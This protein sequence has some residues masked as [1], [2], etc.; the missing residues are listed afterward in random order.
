MPKSATPPQRTESPIAASRIFDP[1]SPRLYSIDQGRPFLADLAG[2]LIDALGQEAPRAEIFLPT[3]RA[4]RAAGDAFMAAYAARGANAAL[5]PRFRAIGDIDDIDL[6]SLSGDAAAEVEFDPAISAVERVI[7]LARFVAAA[8]RR[9]SGQE[10]WPAAIAAA[11]ELGKLLDTFYT[12]EVDPAALDALDIADAAGHWSNA[13][14]FLKIIT[15]RWPLYLQSISRIDPARRR[16]L[17][18]AATA[19]RIERSAPDHPIIIAGTTAS[20]PAVARLVSAIASAPRGLAVLPGLDR[21]ID[22]RAWD[23]IGGEDAHPQAGLHALLARLGVDRSAVKTWPGSN[24]ADS[25]LQ[26]LALALRPAEATDDWLSL[27]AAMT[28]ADAGLAKASEGLSLIEAD[29][30]EA[31]ATAIAALFR[32]TLE[33]P[34]KSAALVTPDR[35]LARRV[36]LKMRRWNVAV[37]DSAGVPFANTSCGIFLRLVALYLENPDDSVGILALLRHPRFNVG[38]DDRRAGAAIDRLDRGLRGAGLPGPLDRLR[39]TLKAD[40]ADD[41]PIRIIDQLTEQVALFRAGADSASFEE[42]FDLHLAAAEA[43]GGGAALWAD[44]DGEAGA[45]ITAEL[46]A[47]ARL[48]ET[49]QGALYADIFNALIAD[50]AVRRSDASHPRLS[51]LGPLEARLQQADLVILGGLNEGVWPQDPPT[52]PFLSRRMRADLGL[53]SPERRTGLSA[54]DFAGLAAQGEVV[55]TRARRAG[56]KPANPSRW[57]IRLKNILTGA[58]AL[59]KVDRSAEWKRIIERLEAPRRVEAA[60]R[61]RPH[62]GPG[63][64]PSRASVTRISSWLRDPYGAYAMYLL[65]LRKIEDPGAP[66]S[67]R[68]MGKL[69]HRAF[70]IAAKD[71]EPPNVERLNEIYAA[72]A[73]QFGLDDADRRFWSVA[74]LKSFVWFAAFDAH[75]RAVGVAAGLEAD[76]EWT[77]PGIDPPFTV[78]AR[79]DRIDVTHDGAAEI[80]DYKLGA[81]PSEKQIRDFSPQ[82]PLIG[83][84][85]EAGG[86]AD[87]GA[88]DVRSYAYLRVANRKDAGA[89]NSFEKSG[90]DATLSIRE[91]TQGL[92]QW[93]RHYDDPA[94]VYLPQPRPE[95]TNDYGD[96]DQ[97]SRRKEWGADEDGD[98]DA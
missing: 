59:A 29:N 7:M 26:L 60:P 14:D 9:F 84:I 36:A 15:Q 94:S 70:E 23:A 30:E 19:E 75:R 12:E 18:I 49:T 76:G 67:Q 46:R 48:I 38:G 39:A 82:L 69:L 34:G 21:T 40:G 3:R 4:V 79:A 64:R 87:I 37:D 88:R 41:E 32:L 89:E 57:I 11:R 17:M 85:I 92:T 80:F 5:L 6:L 27:V 56:G 63:R 77:L 1:Q 53:P 16:A 65:E 58:D 96:Y 68:E 93:V 97:L 28:A 47:S 45:E 71:A 83:A 24:E 52:D 10:N 51:I 81:T 91:A 13:L 25:R 90:D 61:P 62:G 44:D 2:A 98:G 43:L 55:F 31:E 78:T 74:V 35:Q 73:S 66:F 72:E 22:K 95:F 86:F 54:H 8:D 20:A 50:R 33:T 42:R